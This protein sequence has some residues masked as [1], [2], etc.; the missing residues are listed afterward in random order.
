[1]PYALPYRYRPCGEPFLKKGPC[2]KAFNNVLKPSVQLLHTCVQERSRSLERL[3]CFPP[4]NM[5]NIY[6]S[7]IGIPLDINN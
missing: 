3:N 5:R 4:L 1:M 2:S 7:Y 6:K